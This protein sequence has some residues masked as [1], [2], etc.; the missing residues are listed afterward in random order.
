[1]AKT[2]Y[3]K[4]VIEVQNFTEQQQTLKHNDQRTIQNVHQLTK[5][6]DAN[7]FDQKISNKLKYYT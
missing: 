2:L 5:L 4:N 3:M 6:R 1:M 7:T